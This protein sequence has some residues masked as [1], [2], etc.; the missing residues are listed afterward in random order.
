MEHF[1]ISPSVFTDR[2]VLSV[3]TEKIIVGNE[4]IKK[5]K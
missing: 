1:L 3:Y 5:E 2:N 4:G